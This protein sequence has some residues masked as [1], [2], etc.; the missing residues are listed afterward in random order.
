MWP[1][2]IASPKNYYLYSSTKTELIESEHTLT[3]KTERRGRGFAIGGIAAA[4]NDSNLFNEHRP[5]SAHQFA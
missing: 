5:E 4:A 3:P 1:F 2:V